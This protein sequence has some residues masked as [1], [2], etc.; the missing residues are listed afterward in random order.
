MYDVQP[1]LHQQNAFK[2]FCLYLLGLRGTLTLPGLTG[3][4]FFCQKNTKRCFAYTCQ[5]VMEPS[6]S[7][8]GRYR[9]FYPI[10]RKML[11]NLQKI[12]FFEKLALKF[13][14]YLFVNEIVFL[15]RKLPRDGDIF[16]LLNKNTF[17][18]EIFSMAMLD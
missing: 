2:V 8:L 14:N 10:T 11:V 16:Q 15:I 4:G 17:I 13:A 18:Y 7:Q 6:L 1:I 3:I 5:A 9:F 12:C